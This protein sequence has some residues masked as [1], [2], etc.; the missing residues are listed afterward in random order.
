MGKSRNKV[1]K[2]RR[3]IPIE[4]E[5]QVREKD[6]FAV[7]RVRHGPDISTDTMTDP[8]TIDDRT[9]S[10]SEPQ[11]KW[12]C[13]TDPTQIPTSPQSPTN[14]PSTSHAEALEDIG[15]LRDTEFQVL[16]VGEMINL[17]YLQEDHNHVEHTPNMDQY[18][19]EEPHQSLL[20]DSQLMSTS[21]TSIVQWKKK[22]S[23]T[24]PCG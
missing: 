15:I 24:Y 8:N 4:K 22:E 12:L 6:M 20:Q 7:E 17:Q 3:N 5:N 13:P 18:V 2:T 11:V 10:S 9:M 1:R 23:Q 19:S 16:D 21:P 14:N